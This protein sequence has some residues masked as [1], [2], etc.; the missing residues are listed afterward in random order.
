MGSIYKYIS[1]EKYQIYANY[2]FTINILMCCTY[3]IAF[4][5]I[6]GIY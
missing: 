2:I 1:I 6:I 3:S 5:N 4:Y